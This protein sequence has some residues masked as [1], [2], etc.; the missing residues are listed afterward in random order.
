MRVYSLKK[1]RQKS[2]KKEFEIMKKAAFLLSIL[3]FQTFY[4]SCMEKPLR[5]TKS[6]FL[7][8]QC[9]DD[10]ELVSFLENCMVGNFV[11]NSETVMFLDIFDDEKFYERTFSEASGIFNFT[12]ACLKIMPPAE[13]PILKQIAIFIQSNLPCPSKLLAQLFTK[14][15]IVEF[16]YLKFNGIYQDKPI[17]N[18]KKAFDEGDPVKIITCCET[19]AKLRSASLHAHLDELKQK[20]KESQKR[21][22]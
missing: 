7:F 20:L 18:L 11:I 6:N 12:E 14:D 8:Y 4:S 15:G 13:R 16:Q 21:N 19:L 2:V 17:N 9:E 5:Q 1:S 3:L 10:E 22:H